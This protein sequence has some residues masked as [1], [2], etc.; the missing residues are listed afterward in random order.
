MVDDTAVVVLKLVC[1]SCP[2]LECEEFGYEGEWPFDAGED[3]VYSNP[4]DGDV[5]VIGEGQVFYAMVHAYDGVPISSFVDKGVGGVVL[6]E[7][8]N[9]G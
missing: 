8:L 1:G 5:D 4:D 2:G 6:L 9:V 3:V 7:C